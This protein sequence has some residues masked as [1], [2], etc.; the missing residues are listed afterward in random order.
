MADLLEAQQARR[1]S[2]Q[3]RPAAREQLR[4]LRGAHPQRSKW[5]LQRVPNEG[6]LGARGKKGCFGELKR[7]VLRK[8]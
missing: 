3:S 2:S 5:L 8:F 1:R 7:T 4:P 6:I